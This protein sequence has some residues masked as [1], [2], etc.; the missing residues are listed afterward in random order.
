VERRLSNICTQVSGIGPLAQFGLKTIGLD[1]RA[2]EEL[3]HLDW[4]E[5]IKKAEAEK[6]QAA[7]WAKMQADH[8]AKQAK[9]E[10]EQKQQM[11]QMNQQQQQ[12]QGQ[13]GGMGGM[14]SGGMGGY[15]G[16][17]GMSSMGRMACVAAPIPAVFDKHQNT[18]GVEFLQQRKAMLDDVEHRIVRDLV[19][20]LDGD[21]GARPQS[22]PH[23]VLLEKRAR[24]ALIQTLDD[25]HRA[26][27]SADVKLRLSEEE[28]GGMIGAGASARVLQFFGGPFDT[29]KLRRVE[30]N[31]TNHCI[32]FHTDYSYRTMQIPLNEPDEY[33]GGNLLFATAAGFVQPERIPGSPIIHTKNT[34]HGVTALTT[35]VRY[36]LF[37]CDTR[38]DSAAVGTATKT[39]NTHELDPVNAAEVDLDYLVGPVLGQF[40]FFALA[41][42]FL[43]GSS[44]AQLSKAVIEY[45]EFMARKGA[46]VMHSGHNRHATFDASESESQ[47]FAVELVWR[48]HMLHPA[49]YK[50]DCAT[51][52]RDSLVDRPSGRTDAD[53]LARLMYHPWPEAR[54]V[55]GHSDGAAGAQWPRPPPVYGED[56]NFE[57]QEVVVDA[58]AEDPDNHSLVF[59]HSV[60]LVAA[61]RRQAQ[62]MKKIL[63]RRFELA[64]PAIVAA[65]VGSYREFL[66][67]IRQSVRTG[68]GLVP[69]NAMV[70]LVWHTHQQ[71]PL[72]YASE[73][74]RIVGHEINHD[75]EQ[76]DGQLDEGLELTRRAYSAAFAH[77][78][79]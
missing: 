73:C 77:S 50:D 74:L 15:G 27:P 33:C 31:D 64:K 7:Y 67:V 79:L 43:E 38:Q 78:R 52:L 63:E 48:T 56:V 23:R 76:P 11:E 47:S 68:P 13:M 71:W 65:G 9:Q 3:N 28:L 39:A 18:P 72:R 30:A 66:T 69:P 57:L 6:D 12:Q 44:D 21:P 58:T 75:D 1:P 51:L 61:M 42:P 14:R 26:Q 22:F 17:M 8:F 20:E 5:I 45:S 41:V 59:A 46:A 34:V 24:R 40:D 35:G 62:F 53:V 19:K 10:E 60:D 29:I 55:D 37:V 25:L 54:V 16:G 49:A 36:S 4:T 32:A 2:E 70:D